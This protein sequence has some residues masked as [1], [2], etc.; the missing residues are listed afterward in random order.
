MEE[1]LKA[2]YIQEVNQSRLDFD[3]DPEYQMY[4]TQAEELWEEG[5]IPPSIFHLLERSDF[6]SFACGLRLGLELAEWVREGR[7]MHPK[8]SF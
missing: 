5:D 6:L 3:R 4:Y 8:A 2:L 1:K 7:G